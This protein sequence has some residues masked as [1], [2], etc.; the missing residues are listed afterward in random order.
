MAEIIDFQE[1]ALNAGHKKT[2]DDIA[3]P[4]M[5]DQIAR[6]AAEGAALIRE[7]SGI[8]VDDIFAIKVGGVTMYGLKRR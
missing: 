4:V 1:A 8:M 2:L 6:Y 3:T 5:L 7:Q